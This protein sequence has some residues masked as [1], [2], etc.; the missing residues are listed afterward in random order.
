MPE[1]VNYQL[2]Q[3]P[4][5]Q[6]DTNLVGRSLETITAGNKEALQKQ[7]ELR[8]AIAN[9]DLN[10]AED[11][12]RQQLFDD[13]NT[14]IENN[15][16]EGNA[17]YA[18]DDIIKK[19]GDISSNPALLGRLRA[20]QAYKQFQTN[21]DAR[22]DLNDDTKAWA[23]AMNPY[24]YQDKVD[25]NTGKVIGGTEWK[26]DITPV[27]DIDFNDILKLAAQYV[28]PDGGTIQNIT[29]I[30]ANGRPTSSPTGALAR[31]NTTTNTWEAITPA[32]LRA[33]IE[34][35][36]NANPEYA[37]G[38]RQAYTVLQ[39]KYENG[40]NADALIDTK[41]G[42][43]KSFEQYID[44]IVNPFIRARAYYNSKSQQN[45]NDAAFAAL[46]A[47]RDS[48]N[49]NSTN[50][51]GV[52][53]MLNNNGAP[54]IDGFRVTVQDDTRA[55]ALLTVDNIK[56]TIKNDI[57]ALDPEGKI[58]LDIVDVTSAD[59]I[60]KVLSSN[61]ISDDIINSVIASSRREI[62]QN[63]EA[64]DI[65]NNLRSQN[66]KEAAA[67]IM[68]L[69]LQSGVDVSQ[70]DLNNNEY[71]NK[72]YKE[73][74]QLVANA[75]D[76]ANNF[77][78]VTNDKKQFDRLV[79]M[80]GGNEETL[81]TLGYNISK[82]NGKY[83]VSIDRNHGYL[84]AN[85]QGA[86]AKAYSESSTWRKIGQS[87]NR[88]F[89]GSGDGFYRFNDTGDR[90]GVTNP[91]I[92]SLP[93]S[94]VRELLPGDN[95]LV[96]D[97][98]RN[99]GLNLKNDYIGRAGVNQFMRN[100]LPL[101]FLD[102][103][104]NTLGLDT[105]NPIEYTAPMGA[106][107]KRMNDTAGILGESDMVEVAT[108]NFPGITPSHNYY[109]QIIY[110]TTDKDELNFADKK[111]RETEESLANAIARGSLLEGDV[112]KLNYSTGMYEEINDGNK[113]NYN[114]M[115]ND[116]DNYNTSIEMQYNPLLG[117][118]KT[119][120][121]ITKK[122][123]DEQPIQLITDKLIK[124]N[125]FDALNESIPYKV[126]SDLYRYDRLGI[127]TVFGEY[128][129]KNDN[130]ILYK[131]IPTNDPNYRY[132]VA[133]DD[134]LSI[135]STD[136]AHKLHELME[137]IKQLSSDLYGAPEEYKDFVQENKQA[138]LNNSIIKDVFGT[139]ELGKKTAEKIFDFYFGLS[140]EQAVN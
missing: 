101:D 114:K 46:A 42:R 82:Q 18:L 77:G 75:F 65:Y 38:L 9:M 135:I 51:P 7:S 126:G 27:K 54:G 68:K 52:Q 103:N 16:F 25:E 110:S 94:A 39:W 67:E 19:A 80:L 111:V 35:A 41:T 118:M 92:L 26:P 12:F 91:S 90:Y 71:L 79:S 34:A 119:L 72:Y 58:N 56:S 73:Y 13:I 61:G 28:T 2:Q 21:V 138:Y 74:N 140:N 109:K 64:F 22:T 117:K 116:T 47:N 37:A 66:T 70:E 113:L 100:G 23:K 108:T 10:E 136:K 20:Q 45:Y 48:N 134:I 8:A 133:N 124:T 81:K 11:G 105:E 107:Q 40:D 50:N 5:R 125:E 29:F 95:N 1:F 36:M 17:Y 83:I 31:L 102:R 32:K 93:A 15:S 97:T 96:G 99:R 55:K 89:V 120:I 3:M 132:V 122:G 128:Y 62:A 104:F 112:E 86:G 115:M 85:L 4:I 131:T 106:F 98:V 53:A 30:D 43:P 88:R 60:R 33:G 44:D 139:N 127:G 76:K 69:S 63:R 129:D 123:K 24:H 59:S 130:P 14:A 137:R 49:N 6:I 84:M 121:S 87:L 57:A 78:Y